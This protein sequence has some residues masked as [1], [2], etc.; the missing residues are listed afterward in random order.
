MMAGA[1]THHYDEEEDGSESDSSSNDL[2]AVVT[3]A[4]NLSNR[5]PPK[6]RNR[7]ALSC[8][9]CRERKVKCDR[10]IPCQQCIKRG[11]AEFCHL[12]PSKRGPA[13]KSKAK[14]AQQTDEHANQQPTFDAGMQGAPLQRQG[15][16][17]SPTTSSASEVD[18][19]KARLAQLEQVLA[20]RSSLDVSPGFGAQ[21]SSDVSTSSGVSPRYPW[22]QPN[23]FSTAVSTSFGASPLNQTASVASPGNFTTHRSGSASSPSSKNSLTTIF[24][25]QQQAGSNGT[26]PTNGGSADHSPIATASGLRSSKGAGTRQGVANPAGRSTGA[27]QTES[28][29]AEEPQAPRG[30]VDSDTEDA[31]L[32][33]EGL[34]MGAR[35]EC[36]A[37]KQ[38]KPD[39]AALEIIEKPPAKSI[40]GFLE[41]DKAEDIMTEGKYRYDSKVAV[42]TD[43]ECSSGSSTDPKQIEACN[44]LRDF[45]R[46]N[47]DAEIGPDGQRLSPAQRVCVLLSEHNSLFT[48][49]WGPETFLG[50]GLGWAFP[51]AEAAGDMMDVSEIVGCKGALQREAVLRAIIRSLPQRETAEHLVDVFDSRVKFLAGNCFHM[52]TFKREMS[53][54]YDLD[55]VEKRARVINFV[56]PAW[57][58]LMLMTFVLAL[59]FHPCERPELVKH[60]FDGRTIHLWR[61]AAQTCLVLARYQSSTSMAVLQTIILINLMAMGQGKENFSLTH[62]AI[63]NAL[64]MGL[65][66]LGDKDKQPKQGESPAISIRREMAKRIWHQLTFTDW[67]SASMH[68]GAYRIHPHQFNTPVPGN[69]NDEDLCQSP[70]P[71]PRPET[72][73]SDMSYTLAMLKL[74][75]VSRQNVDMLHS[76][77]SKRV[78]CADMAYLDTSY[79][80]L[81]E[82]A[83]SFYKIGSDEG[84]GENLEVERWLFQQSVFHKLLRLHRPQLSSRTSARTSCVL[85]ARSILDMQRRIRSRCSVVDRLF[86]NLAQSFSAAIVLCLDLLQTRPS[87]TMRSIVRGEIFEA[88]KALRHVGASHHTTENSIRVIE[89]LLEEEEARWNSPQGSTDNTGKRRRDGVSNHVGERRKNMLNLALRVAKAAHGET[90]SGSEDAEMADGEQASSGEGS[91]DESMD[92]NAIEQRAKDQQ[93]RQMFEQLLTGRPTFAEPSSFS[94]A[95]FNANIF[96]QPMGTLAPN[97]LDFGSGWTPPETANGQPFDL[98]KF[99]AEAD[100][101][102]SPSNDNLASSGASDSGHSSLHGGGSVSSGRLSH[103]S[104]FSNGNARQ[105]SGQVGGDA[106]GSPVDAFGGLGGPHLSPSAFERPSTNLDGFWN[107][108]LTQGSMGFGPSTD[109]ASQ[110]PLG[111]GGAIVNT[112]AQGVNRN[113]VSSGAA[114]NT[115]VPQTQ[116][117]NAL[118]QSLAGGMGANSVQGAANSNQ[119]ASSAVASATQNASANPFVARTP[120][121][122]TN[123]A[124]AGS[125]GNDVPFYSVG[126][127]SAGMGTSWMSTPGLFD[128]AYEFGD[129]ITGSQSSAGAANA[130]SNGTVGA[131]A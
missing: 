42:D 103:S 19:I 92:V 29:D 33:L 13:P 3:Q 91:R 114:V 87:A 99:L 75:D 104:S 80:G 118:A 107:W 8:T 47:P 124:L 51:A 28:A 83:P 23:S 30:D 37:K 93:S 36:G 68:S 101:N 27:L 113:A 6:K 41:E 121:N 127:P 24:A 25:Q 52:P 76:S 64:E 100:T 57:L 61:S 55:T 35:S 65:H 110:A 12:D 108:V 122:S 32:V 10:V 129:G 96:D 22:S 102:S 54:F 59:H 89:A 106:S 5:P 38:L 60:L 4:G 39:R 112:G 78:L 63:S 9:L 62:T 116:Y 56:D 53:A 73:H 131:P 58:S 2:S 72:E 14:R 50:W 45:L 85:L 11:D 74:A 81:L 17:S 90:G 77:E 109:Q 117:L 66:R 97:G 98:T 115:R 95:P 119:T 20:Q 21:G 69:Y 34:A 126:T 86:V 82:Q 16:A 48:L 84:A 7:A 49:V 1:H 71:P 94:N 128:F 88:L 31:A 67:C 111:G 44:L 15:S 130:P 105:A 46:K 70:Q 125:G 18:A 79:R 26:S 123:N 120:T 43:K 40:Q